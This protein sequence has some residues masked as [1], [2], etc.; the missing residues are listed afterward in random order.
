MNAKITRRTKIGYGVNTSPT[1]DNPGY[2]FELPDSPMWSGTWKTLTDAL[3]SDRYLNSLTNTYYSESYFVKVKGTWFRVANQQEFSWEMQ[4]LYSTRD[5]GWG[6]YYRTDA[7]EVEIDYV[8][9]TARA[10]AQLGKKPKGDT[11]RANGRK[12]IKQ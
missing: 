10:A 11:S 9:E 6:E 7:V 1:Q 3:D 2:H 5:D 4:E 12:H 8:S